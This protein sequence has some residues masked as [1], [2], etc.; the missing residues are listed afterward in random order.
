[1]GSPKQGLQEPCCQQ[2][3]WLD[4]AG[5]QGGFKENRAAKVPLATLNPARLFPTSSN[6]SLLPVA[7][8]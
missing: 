5:G 8:P 4:L 2:R 3:D 7:A 6:L 1:M